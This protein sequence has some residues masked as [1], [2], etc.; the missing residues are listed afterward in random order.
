MP[1]LTKIADPKDL[2]NIVNRGNSRIEYHRQSLLTSNA[3]VETPFVRVE[4]G[5]YSFGVYEEKTRAAGN[6]GVYKNVSAKYPNYIKSLSIKKINGTVNQYTLN[7]EYPVTENDDPN[8][9][10]KLFSSISKTRLISITYGDF[11]SPEYIY[12]DEQ[13][14]ITNIQTG[15]DIKSSKL[16]YIIS[17]TSTST[18][19]LSG[20]YIFKT[21]IA[22][23]SDVIK[24]LIQNKKYKLQEVFTGMRDWGRVL[25]EN[26][27]ASDDAV[28]TI[29]TVVNKSALD[30]IQFL[31]SYMKEAGSDDES[32][33]KQNVYNL[34]THDDV[35]G[36][37]GGPYLTVEKLQSS[38]SALENLTT[39]SV[40]I[41]YIT[42]AI[43]TDFRIS[44]SENWSIFYDY[45]RSLNSSDYLT[46]INDNGD[47][48]EIY[49]PQ[50]TGI[51]YDIN[52]SD[53]TWWSKVTEFP[54]SASITIKGLLRPAILMNYVKL[55]VWFYGRK[56]TSSGYY[57]ITAQED[58]IDESGYRTK[59]AL[60]RI[61][62]DELM[63]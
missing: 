22:K 38:A 47:I 23:P 24:E 39:Y 12:R 63:V 31:V 37:H 54:I 36:T 26:M 21:K 5:G 32:P 61:A 35:D 57:I 46:R 25:N 19:T 41:G 60:T 58:T 28:I 13:A 43:V 16:S 4:I 10:E 52:E 48:E 45:N 17:A 49:S 1:D 51:N 18:V 44:N 50:L 56:H 7:I 14:I 3:R 42:S 2:S 53:R 29:P 59:L 20:N 8:F 34:S 55:N 9:F 6:N 11:S 30:Y 33:I 15:F 27:I 62:G 40:D